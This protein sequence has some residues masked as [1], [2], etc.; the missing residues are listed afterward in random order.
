MTIK[1]KYE[2]ILEK[3][4]IKEYFNKGYKGQNVKIASIESLKSEHGRNVYLTLKTY[5]PLCDVYSFNDEVGISAI[6]DANTS[7]TINFPKFVD[8]CIEKGIRVV[9]SSLD[10][11]ADEP[12]EVKAIQKLYDNGI[13][14]FNC[15]GNKGKEIVL[16]ESDKASCIDEGVVAVSSVTLDS[17]GKFTWTGYNYGNAVDVVTI[18][19]NIPILYDIDKFMNWSGTSSSTPF[20]AAMSADMISA[21]DSINSKNIEQIIEDSSEDFEYKGLM[22]NR[23]IMP[24]LEKLEN[25][26]L[27]WKEEFARSWQKAT[28]LKIVDGLRPNEN[29]TRNELIVILDRLEL[30]KEV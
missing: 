21:N 30:L 14:F 3:L 22:Y 1:E 10:W 6:G 2:V 23:F 5:A 16:G 24:T 28:K 7:D 20:L 4:N 12:E 13:I 8:W 18:G 26:V 19:Y 27:T 25:Y 17:K 29:I 15:A 11:N 9:S